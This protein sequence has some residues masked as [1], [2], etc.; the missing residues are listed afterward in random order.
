MPTAYPFPDHQ[1]AGGDADTTI[2]LLHGAYGSKDYFRYEI[3]T[4]CRAGYRVVAWDATGYGISPLPSEGLNI[5]KMAET[6]G[7]LIDRTGSKTNI[8]LGHSMGGVMAPAVYAARPDKVHAVVVSASVGSFSH[9]SEEDRKAFLAERIEPLKHGKPF[10]E[11]AALVLDSMFAPT[12]KGPMV[13]LVRSVALSTS[14]DTFCA[15]I[16]AIVDYNGEPNLKKLRIP[17]LLLAGKF[18]QVGR[19]ESMQDT[20]T[21]FV[22]HADYVCL[23]QSAHYAFAE[24]HELFNRHLLEFIREQVCVGA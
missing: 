4:L 18:D 8:V 2:Y 16:A 5:E 13:D 1:V 24:E 7:Q 9:F 10:R 12:S 17:T 21:R 23:P 19:P 22:P 6:A 14:V 11:T 20:K 3:E 15:A